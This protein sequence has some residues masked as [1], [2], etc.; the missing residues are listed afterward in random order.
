MTIVV[1]LAIGLLPGF[2]SLYACFPYETVAND[3]LLDM[4][5]LHIWVAS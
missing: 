5:I 1:C 2:V 3:V 4:I